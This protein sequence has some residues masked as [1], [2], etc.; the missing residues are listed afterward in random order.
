MDVN[1]DSPSV[2]EEIELRLFGRPF[3]ELDERLSQSRRL[4]RVWEVIGLGYEDASLNLK[5]MT[6]RSGM[7]RTQL[8]E[9]LKGK[10]GLT[11]HEL[12]TRFRLW[13]A[14][15]LMVDR[16]LTLTEIADQTGFDEL[17]NFRR[18]FLKRLEERPRPFRE[19]LLASKS[20][21]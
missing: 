20:E 4:W 16:E 15:H 19:S 6:R 2:I 21:E 3:A 7:G 11:P 8:T 14:V 13:R 5:S 10:I 9:R 17:G 1:D 18:H 12:L